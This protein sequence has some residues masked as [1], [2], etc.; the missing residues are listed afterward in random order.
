MNASDSSSAVLR[1]AKILSSVFLS[2]VLATTLPSCTSVPLKPEIPDHISAH[3][4]KG[5]P[6]GEPEKNSFAK[7][8]GFLKERVTKILVKKSKREL[9]LLNALGDVIKSY[10]VSLGF[11]PKGDKLCQGD[12]R[13]P[14]GDY[15]ITKHNPYSHYH[16]SME[17]S[18][19][20][21]SDRKE[22]RSRGCSTGG[23]IFIHGMPN[24]QSPTDTW[25][26]LRNDWTLGCVALLNPDIKEI[27]YKVPDGTPITIQP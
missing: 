6:T 26:S 3:A 25:H 8:I 18:Y 12:G 19:P 20:S 16:L 7:A 17:I 9:E 2:A 11:E 21:A 27:Y 24:D 13:T 14:E 10:K 22:A 4:I 5:K 23:N 15:K 1:P